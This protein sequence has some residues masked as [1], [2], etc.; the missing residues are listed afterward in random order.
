MKRLH[1]GV[2][3]I[4]VLAMA[5]F[6]GCSGS[7]SEPDV[8]E[9]YR[10]Y[11]DTS[12]EIDLV[13]YWTGQQTDYRIAAGSFLEVSAIRGPSGNVNDV[14]HLADSVMVTFDN[15]A[16]LLHRQGE[17]RPINILSID[18]Y[19]RST[20]GENTLFEYRFTSVDLDAAD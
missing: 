4:N 15:A 14:I 20:E 12:V 13:R 19:A 2:L 7:D 17:T 5:V 16:S 11:N 8:T 9:L 10:Y 3:L 18:N 6:L 1:F